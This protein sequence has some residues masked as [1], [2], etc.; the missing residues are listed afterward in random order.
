M[1]PGSPFWYP[2][3]ARAASLPDDAKAIRERIEAKYSI[4]D[5]DFALLMR[6]AG[7]ETEPARRR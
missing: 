3:V 2:S 5:E 6:Q 7:K 1:R 4:T